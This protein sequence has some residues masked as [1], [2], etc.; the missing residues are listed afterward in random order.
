MELGRTNRF[1]AGVCLLSALGACSDISFDPPEAQGPA[2][3]VAQAGPPQLWVLSKQE[4]TRSVGVSS[5]VRPTIYW[6]QDTYF[7]FQVQAFDPATARPLWSRRLLTLGDDQPKSHEPSRVVGSSAD[8]RLLGQDGD[9]VW[10]MLNQRPIALN[11]ADGRMLADAPGLEQRNPE[12][13]GLLPIDAGH[14]AFDRGL[15]LLAAD[16]RRFVIRGPEL[17]AEP[18]VPTPQPPD[19][20]AERLANGHGRVTPTLPSGDVPARLAKI[21]ADWVAL[22]SE[23]E[24]ADAAKDSFGDN[25]RYPYRVINE[26]ALVRRSLWRPRIVSARRFDDVFDRF[27]SFAPIPG[28][29]SF[30]QGRFF[31]DPATGQPMPLSSPTG[32]LVWHSTRVDSAG[33]LALSRLDADLRTV[34]TREL[35]L[36]ENSTSTPVVSWRVADGLVVTGLRESTE[37]G[38]RLQEPHL[39][40]IRLADGAMQAWNLR[41]DAAVD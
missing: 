27:E 32:L 36:S 31:K 41:R 33:R 14:Y 35:P 24:A 12:L 16:A 37:D 21:D 5:G 20:P 2:A 25:L 7:H 17:R 8:G 13:A 6:R 11:A 39:V 15:V 10:L 9:V 4:E 22:Y 40:A 38:L 26:G 29:P 1:L 3:M 34:W 18:Y 28:A 30:I 23:K 19:P